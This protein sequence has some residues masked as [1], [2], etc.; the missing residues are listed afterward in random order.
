MSAAVNCSIA[1]SCLL[2]L[3][4]SCIDNNDEPQIARRMKNGREPRLHR[5]FYVT[6]APTTG[7]FRMY[8]SCGGTW[9]LP[10]FA[11]TAASCFDIDGEKDRN[12]RLAGT[13]QNGVTV[14]LHKPGK[15]LPLY[16]YGPTVDAIA[17][18][19]Q[20]YEPSGVIY[21]KDNIALVRF[22]ERVLIDK[23]IQMCTGA[24]NKKSLSMMGADQT[25]RDKLTEARVVDIGCLV[26]PFSKMVGTINPVA[27]ICTVAGHDAYPCSEDQG[28][29]LVEI[30]ARTDE[31]K[32]VYG[33]VSY[34]GP[35]CTTFTIA[36]KLS[37]YYDWIKLHERR[38]DGEY[39]RNPVSRAAGKFMT[40][41]R[42]SR[43]NELHPEDPVRPQNGYQRPLMRKIFGSSEDLSG[44]RHLRLTTDLRT[45]S[46][47]GSQDGLNG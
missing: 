7:T 32:C 13:T 24:V 2:M 42:T 3:L 33:I 14:T 25:K 26:H 30:D 4:V 23:S 29:P 47:T 21:K 34:S 1:F 18:I 16:K 37:A 17:Y 39:S 44:E 36:T 31:A 15:P 22:N 38:M 45:G 9:I 19:H 10:N 5:S 20:S 6:I 43:W 46:R 27:Q 28:G 35:L 8:H 12:G 40:T 41:V 11:L